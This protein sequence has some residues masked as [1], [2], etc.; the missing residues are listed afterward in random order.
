MPK[1]LRKNPDFGVEVDAMPGGFVCSGSMK[2]ARGRGRGEEHGGGA[3]PLRK[4]F[5]KEQR[6]L[7]DANAP[8]GVT[9]ED[10]VVLGPIPCSRCG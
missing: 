6:A 1:A 3:S 7:F 9:F 2:A 5:T 4:L 8:E 10:L